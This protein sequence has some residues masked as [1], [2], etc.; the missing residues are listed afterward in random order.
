MSMSVVSVDTLKEHLNLTTCDDDTLLSIKLDTAHQLVESYT[1]RLFSEWFDD[2]TEVYSTPAP[3]VEAVLQIAAGL[4]ENREGAAFAPS[5]Y[6]LMAPY[7]TW[8]F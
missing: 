5:T 8:S 7:R 2:A 4:Y 3:L 1:G 6:S